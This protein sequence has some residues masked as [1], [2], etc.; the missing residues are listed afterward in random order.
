MLI[1]ANSNHSKQRRR[2]TIAHEL[3]HVAHHTAAARKDLSFVTAAELLRSIDADV[4]KER[5]CNRIAAEILMPADL[6]LRSVFSAGKVDSYALA[7]EYDVSLTAVRV[8]LRG[9]GL[10]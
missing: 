8:R 4:P 1:S 2:F 5:L 3:A 9:L 6:L 10:L 7:R